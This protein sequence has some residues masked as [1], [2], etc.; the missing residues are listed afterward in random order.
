MFPLPG[1][2]RVCPLPSTPIRPRGIGT[3][4]LFS[5][6]VERDARRYSKLTSGVLGQRNSGANVGLGR[7]MLGRNYGKSNT[8]KTSVGSWRILCQPLN[9]TVGATSVG[10]EQEILKNEIEKDKE[11]G[12]GVGG[13]VGIEKKNTELVE[14]AR[15]EFEKSDLEEVQR[16]EA[17]FHVATFLALLVVGIIVA[18]L[19]LFFTSNIGFKTAVLKIWSRLLK[20][21][22]AKQTL[23]IVFTMFFV[24]LGLT[25]LVRLVRSCFNIKSA[26]ETSTEAYLLGEIYQP[27]ELLLGVAACATLAENFLPPLISVPRSMIHHVVRTVLSLTFIVSAGRVGFTVKKRILQETKWKMELN[28]KTSEQRRVEAI[29]KLTTVGIFFLTIVLGMQAVGLDVNSLLAIGGIGGIAIGLAGRD[30]F[31]NVFSGFLIMGARPFDVGDEVLF[32][33]E[34]KLLEGIVLDIGWYNTVIRSFEREMYI[35]PNSVFSKQVVLNITRKGREWRFIETIPIRV[36]DVEKVEAIVSDMRRVIR[37]D[38]RV[39]QKLYRRVFLH[40]ITREYVSIFIAFYLDMTNRDAFLAARQQMY[41]AFLDCIHRN[42]A[43]VAE[44]KLL[45]DFD[46]A[47]AKGL[48]PPGPMDAVPEE[49]THKDISEAIEN[50]ALAMKPAEVTD[51]VLGTSLKTDASLS[52]GFTPMSLDEKTRFGDDA[53]HRASQAFNHSSFDSSPFDNLPPSNLQA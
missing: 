48:L 17:S 21:V 23:A 45:V 43:K 1:R 52:N 12:D 18:A 25:P 36:C 27:L 15:S 14:F 9:A 38:E 46:R 3:K 19:T 51:L 28:G 6:L 41:L 40:K 34:G 44:K 53:G 50:A 20:S 42:G 16:A 32:H 11:Q 4:N 8:M 31:E 30:I 7:A 2:S 49:L 35:I 22:A 47:S 10:M 37:Q 33:P 24:R 5:N 13:A 39:M 29:D 26:W